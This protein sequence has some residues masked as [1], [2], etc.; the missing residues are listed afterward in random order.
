MMKNLPPE[1]KVYQYM[2][3]CLNYNAELNWNTNQLAYANT[4]E[5]F[6]NRQHSMQDPRFNRK[7]LSR[8]G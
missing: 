3:G 7:E 4:K 1:E 6:H 8:M 5:F 2:T